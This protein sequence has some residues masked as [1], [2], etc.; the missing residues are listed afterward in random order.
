MKHA[1]KVLVAAALDPVVGAVYTGD[2]VTGVATVDPSSAFVASEVKIKPVVEM[3]DRKVVNNSFYTPQSVPGKKYVEATITV[4]LAG[5]GTPGTPPAWASL[6]EACGCVKESSTDYTAY[7]L[8]FSEKT[9]TIYVWLDGT[10]VKLISGMGNVKLNFP[11]GDLGKVEFTFKGLYETPE[12]VSHPSNSPGAPLPPLV[13]SAGLFV[14]GYAPV[15]QSVSLDFGNDV[16]LRENLNAPDGYSFAYIADR[17]PTGSIDP[18][19]FSRGAHDIWSKLESGSTENLELTIGE[20]EGNKVQ[21]VCPA[22]QYTGAEYGERDGILTMPLNF[23]CTG[24]PEI[25][26]RFY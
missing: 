11:A 13:K 15:A 10:L 14:G 4:E 22:I 16:K 6:F 3:V 2:A 5:S 23:K 12:D 19:A 26:I 8:G 7:K 24:S 25:E 18:D 1:R 9:A 17:N 20:V 21:V